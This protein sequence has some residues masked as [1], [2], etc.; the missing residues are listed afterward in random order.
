M[1]ANKWIMT[2]QAIPMAFGLAFMGYFNQAGNLDMAYYILIGLL[3]V[4]FVTILSMK[5]IKDANEADREYGKA[6]EEKLTVD[7]N[8][9]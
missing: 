8:A 4:S 5:D 7:S 2:I 6:L 9:E 3:V 1:A